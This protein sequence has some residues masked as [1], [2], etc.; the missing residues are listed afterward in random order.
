MKIN[1][2]GLGELDVI[3]WMI[4]TELMDDVLDVMC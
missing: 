3:K 1:I 4:M 2:F